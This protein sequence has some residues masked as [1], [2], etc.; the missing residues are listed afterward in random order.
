MAINSVPQVEGHETMPLYFE[1]GMDGTYTLEATNLETL[2]P[3][4][5]VFLED[6][7]LDY[8]QDMRKNP[9][10]SFGYSSGSIKKFNIHFKDLTGIDE[11]LAEAPAFHCLLSDGRLSVNYIGSSPFEGR[12]IIRVYN[13]AGQLM[14]ITEAKNPH[15]EISFPGSNTIYIVHILYNQ[16]KYA[17]K[18]INQ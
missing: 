14:L 12:S 16:A 8:V 2:N 5:P 18:V 13:L 6:L 4:T 1:A 9:N 3:E 17:T 11:M 15:T 7:S 10:Y